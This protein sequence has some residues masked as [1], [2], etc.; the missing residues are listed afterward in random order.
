[1]KKILLSVILILALVLIIGCKKEP[2]IALEEAPDIDEIE[3]QPENPLEDIVS[4]EARKPL[5]L[6]EGCFYEKD[7]INYSKAGITYY[8]INFMDEEG[9]VGYNFT[10]KTDT[11]IKKLLTADVGVCIYQDR[12]QFFDREGQLWSFRD[13]K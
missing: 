4:A 11:T 9:N 5:V 8:T 3:E 7:F 10:S 1:M 12:W 13:I 2:Y 6:K